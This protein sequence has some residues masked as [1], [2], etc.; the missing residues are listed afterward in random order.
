M[1][2]SENM[3][4]GIFGSSLRFVAGPDRAGL[5][6]DGIPS[7]VASAIY[8]HAQSEGQ[9]WEEK[10][11]VRELEELRA[12]SGGVHLHSGTPGAASAPPAASILEE[13]T[14]AK[15]LLDAG[16]ISDSEFE[17]IKAKVLSRA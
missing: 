4:P 14:R 17:E 10:R 6:I 9:A 8:T 2:L 11:R 16:A 13:I 1:K 7:E 5:H 3:L 15:A 12:E